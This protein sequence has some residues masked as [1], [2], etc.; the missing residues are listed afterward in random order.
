MIEHRLVLRCDHPGCEAGIVG[1]PFRFH[2]ASADVERLVEC[3]VV[4]ESL[5]P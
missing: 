2:G 4:L 1:E 5:G 3:F